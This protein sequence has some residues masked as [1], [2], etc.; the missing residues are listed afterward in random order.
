MQQGQ[1]FL[2]KRPSR[3]CKPV[4]SDEATKLCATPLADLAHVM[5]NSNEFVYIN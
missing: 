3:G 5:M 4:R 2:N 1:E